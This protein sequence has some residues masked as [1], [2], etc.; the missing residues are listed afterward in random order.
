V[1]NLMFFLIIFAHINSWADSNT[2][3]NTKFDIIDFRIE[4]YK[5][6][7]EGKPWPFDRKDTSRQELFALF[8]ESSRRDLIQYMFSELYLADKK[9]YIM[10]LL[11]YLSSTEKKK[12]L[13]GFYKSIGY[14][15]TNMTMTPIQVMENWPQRNKIPSFWREKGQ[16]CKLYLDSQLSIE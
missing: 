7:C 13:R 2:K 3:E 12:S 10:P 14:I 16:L 9:H 6:D 15:A 8:E 1:N 4:E 5:I 11:H